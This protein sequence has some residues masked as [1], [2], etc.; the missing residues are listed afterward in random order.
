MPGDA[1]HLPDGSDL[2]HRCP[3]WA[4][5]EKGNH[6]FKITRKDSHSKTK[7]QLPCLFQQAQIA[8]QPN[9]PD[10][11]ARREALQALNSL[12]EELVSSGP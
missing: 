11:T 8:A 2:L 3:W 5:Q 7:G 10:A 1:L 4:A 12:I 6:M 9:N